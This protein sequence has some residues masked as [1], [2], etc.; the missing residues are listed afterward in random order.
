MGWTRQCQIAD[1]RAV[2]LAEA[3]DDV[4]ERTRSLRET[5]RQPLIAIGGGLVLGALCARMPAGSIA[6][7]IK[8]GSYGAGMLHRPEASPTDLIDDP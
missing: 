4:L 5:L 2:A 7:A 1:A 3:G 8:L 6:M